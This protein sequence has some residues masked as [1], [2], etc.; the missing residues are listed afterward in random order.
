MDAV[1]WL[2]GVAAVGLAL[3]PVL[4]VMVRKLVRRREWQPG[5]LGVAIRWM[6]WSVALR[7]EGVK[8]SKRQAILIDAVR[9]DLSGDR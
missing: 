6:V 8:R 2:H 1:S 9:R 7:L 4:V 3:S 5:I